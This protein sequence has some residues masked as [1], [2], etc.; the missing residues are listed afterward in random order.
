LTQFYVC[1]SGKVASGVKQK[2]LDIIGERGSVDGVE[3]AAR[4]DR[5]IKASRFTMDVFE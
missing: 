4:M 2:L 3:A 5:I 1:G